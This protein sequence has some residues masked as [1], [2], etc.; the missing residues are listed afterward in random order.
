MSLSVQGYESFMPQTQNSLSI[1]ALASKT[2]RQNSMQS[3]A[4]GDTGC[5]TNDSSM[6]DFVA[7][8][9]QAQALLAANAQNT[10]N[11]S[12]L[13]DDLGTPA[14]I[15]PTA[16]DPHYVKNV[17]LANGESVLQLGD[18][19]GND[20]YFHKQGENDFGYTGTCGLVSVGDVASQ[21]GLN[22]DE[23]YMVHYAV[24]NS[25]CNV[26]TGSSSQSGGT[27]M[28]DQEQLLDGI[29]IPSHIEK[30][31]TL[32]GLGRDL[33]EGRGVIIEVNAGKLWDDP[34]YLASGSFNHAVTVTGVA[35]DPVTGQSIGLWIDDSGTGQ[36]DRYLSAS[37]PAIDDWMQ[38]G[39]FAVVTDV[40][41]A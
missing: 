33:E 27:T 11:A 2:I 18:T 30:G 8:S 13:S 3:T 41:H 35:A 32:D 7:I 25:L 6:E 19:P 40:E 17:S 29:G 16:A 24:N 10:G 22:V 5:G 36:Y 37:D 14:I 4:A 12:S 9:A 21:F 38:V 34:A 26:V 15:S 20:S 23:N 28:D 31:T 1:G 39:S